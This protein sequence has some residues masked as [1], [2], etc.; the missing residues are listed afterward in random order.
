VDP[1]E[2]VTVLVWRRKLGGDELLEVVD[3]KSWRLP[4]R[5]EIGLPC[6]AIDGT[7]GALAEAPSG[8]D[9]GRMH[10]WVPIADAC[11]RCRPAVVA[12]TVRAAERHVGGDRR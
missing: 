4:R 2:A 11:E 10:R 6:I 8:F 5:H 7:I 9:P 3:G 1:L 12:E